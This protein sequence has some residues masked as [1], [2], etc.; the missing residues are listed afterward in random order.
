MNHIPDP[1]ERGEARC[2]NNIREGLKSIE[3]EHR[4]GSEDGGEG[5]RELAHILVALVD[6]IESLEHSIE[7]LEN[8]QQTLFM[9]K[10]NL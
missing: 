5:V 8:E 6:H 3:Y 10:R 2:L 9:T 4:G 7:R 1:I